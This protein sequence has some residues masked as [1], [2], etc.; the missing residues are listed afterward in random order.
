M[1]LDNLIETMKI[2]RLSGTNIDIE[3]TY[4]HMAVVFSSSF[5]PKKANILSYGYNYFSPKKPKSIHAEH[6]V[7]NKLAYSRKAQKINLLVVRFN[8][9][10]KLMNSKPCR[11]CIEMMLDYFPKKGY[12]VKRIWYSNGNGDLIKTIP[13]NIISQ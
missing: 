9:S 6:S 11:K 1:S 2:K 10:G 12:I 5:C 7:I 4:T 13:I 8:P 3:G